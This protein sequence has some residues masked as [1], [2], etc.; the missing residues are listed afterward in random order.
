MFN[1][2][3]GYIGGLLSGR[4]SMEQQQRELYN[5]AQLDILQWEE[6]HIFDE[7][8]E[9]VSSSMSSWQSSTSTS[10]SEEDE[11]SGVD[12]GIAYFESM[13]R[14]LGMKKEEEE[15]FK[16]EEFDI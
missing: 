15:F 7:E 9:Y 12:V 10:S 3:L 6:E 1:T 16:K 4:S 2:L 13:E 11:R 8:D 5:Q 14:R